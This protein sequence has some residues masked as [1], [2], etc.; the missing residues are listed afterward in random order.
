MSQI[1]NWAVECG[2]D[3]YSELNPIYLS[4]YRHCYQRRDLKYNLSLSHLSFPQRVI[5]GQTRL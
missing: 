5:A 4:A 1:K 2:S 3:E